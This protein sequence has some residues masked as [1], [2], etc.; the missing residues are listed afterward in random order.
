MIINV[1]IELETKRNCAT[2]QAESTQEI[3]EDLPLLLG[4]N[5]IEEAVKRLHSLGNAISRSVGRGQ[6][7]KQSYSSSKQ[8][9]NYCDFDFIR[10]KFPHANHSLVEQLDRTIHFRSRSMFYQQR[11][12][13]KIAEVQERNNEAESRV[14]EIIEEPVESAG[15]E[16]LVTLNPPMETNQRVSMSYN[17]YSDIRKEAF[18][19]RMS[20]PNSFYSHIIG[21]SSDWGDRDEIFDYPMK[22]TAENGHLRVSC[23]ICSEQLESASLTEKQWK[24]VI[25]PPEFSVGCFI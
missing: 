24:Y 25:H 23:P 15:P 10:Y 18:P 3:P 7:P 17:K 1:L 19:G 5:A 4:S 9:G 13:K 2:A 11:Y 16:M 22:P 14:K 8:Y 21:D 6:Q 20:Q 12:N